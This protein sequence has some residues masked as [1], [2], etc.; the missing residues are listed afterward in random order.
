MFSALP[1]NPLLKHRR[2]SDLRQQVSDFGLWFFEFC[3]NLFMGCLN[4]CLIMELVEFLGK[5][6]V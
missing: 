1:Q 4:E 2:E 3:L 5:L 6:V